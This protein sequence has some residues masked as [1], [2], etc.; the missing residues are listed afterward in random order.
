MNILVK[1]FHLTPFENYIN[2]KANINWD[3]IVNYVNDL[4]VGGVAV[5]GIGDGWA[6][7][8]V[9]PIYVSSTSMSFPGV[10]YTGFIQK[11][12]KIYIEQSGAK[13]FYVT[14]TAFATDTTVNVTGG[15]DYSVANATIVNPKFSKQET[16]QGFPLQFNWTPGFT[17]FSINP[18]VT[19]A[20]FSIGSGMVNV[21]Y[22]QNANGTSNA[23]GFTITNLPVSAGVSD[24]SSANRLWIGRD[25][26]V[27]GLIV[28][29]YVS[30]T[31][32]TVEKTWATPTSWTASG[33]KGLYQFTISYPF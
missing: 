4:A 21:T 9:T 31:T 16:P 15:S 22:V 18:T 24:D 14:S 2:Q 12:D 17:G 1:Q 3:D 11:G 30:G 7:F 28:Y 25:N 10:N 8:P 26:G 27:G 19:A 23:T 29:C 6:N 32:L 33:S 20:K 5:A 13:Y